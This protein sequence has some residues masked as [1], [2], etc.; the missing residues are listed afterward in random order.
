MTVTRFLPIVLSALVAWGCAPTKPS[1]EASRDARCQAVTEIAETH[2]VLT[3]GTAVIDEG[4]VA[5]T[6]TA[7]EERPGVPASAATRFS[8]ASITKTITAETVLRLAADSRL[9]LDESMAGHW[10]DPDLADDPRHEALTPRHALTHRTGFPNWRFFLESGRLEF[11]R[12]PGAGYGYSGEGF[13][14]LARFLEE[15]LGRG[16]HDLVQETVFDPIG[17]ESATVAPYDPDTTHFALAFDESGR[18][19]GPWC[20]PGGYCTPE[21]SVAAAHGLR[22]TIG[23][24]AAFLVA[25]AENDGYGPAI[26]GDRDRVQTSVSGGDEPAVDCSAGEPCP[27]AQGYGL[28]WRVV[29]GVDDRLLYHGGSD[30]SEVAVAAVSP[31]TG[32]GFVVLLNAPNVRAARAM[33]EVLSV[34]A[35]DSPLVGHYERLRQRAQN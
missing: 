29:D 25:V 27:E 24:L 34:I 26:A 22:V 35:P 12:D 17:M 13:D 16:F 19:Y 33:P 18:A 6:C 5:W 8:A 7:G 14:Y 30:W 1:T 32:D 20:R 11:L 10:V 15:K 23:D 28:G 21:G 31:V 2:G 3:V 4:R 9:S